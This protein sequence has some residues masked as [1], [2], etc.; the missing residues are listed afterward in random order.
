M[1][2]GGAGQDDDA[3]QHDD[4][5]GQEELPA[6]SLAERVEEVHAGSAL[7]Y[8]LS[9]TYPNALITIGILYR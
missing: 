6:Q 4:Q 5:I 9:R 1:E 8:S 3:D 7:R 2:L